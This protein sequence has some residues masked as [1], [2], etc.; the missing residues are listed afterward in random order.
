MDTPTMYGHNTPSGD[1]EDGAEDA[2]PK[3]SRSSAQ[4]A[5]GRT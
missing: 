5:L 2:E 1:L 4:S 3:E